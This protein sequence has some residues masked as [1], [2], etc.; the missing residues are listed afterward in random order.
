MLFELTRIPRSALEIIGIAKILSE[1]LKN[2]DEYTSPDF[3]S[4]LCH[5]IN[6]ILFHRLFLLITQ[7]YAANNIISSYKICEHNK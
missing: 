3:S 7:L 4:Y 2:I 6:Y 1:K 5:D